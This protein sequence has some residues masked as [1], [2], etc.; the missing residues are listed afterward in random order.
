MTPNHDLQRVNV[1]DASHLGHL[2]QKALS[3]RAVVQAQQKRTD[4]FDDLVARQ[5]VTTP[6]Q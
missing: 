6:R 2:K 4:L 3:V 5:I 1:D